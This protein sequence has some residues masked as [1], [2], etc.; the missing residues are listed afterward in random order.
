MRLKLETS[1]AVPLTRQIVEQVRDLCAGGALAPGDRL[2]SIRELAEELSLNPNTIL[3]AYERLTAEGLLERRHG[4]GTYVA[5]N[6]PRGRRRSQE[7]AWET[8]LERLVRRGRLLGLAGK[9]IRARVDRAL[10]HGSDRS[11]M[12]DR[13]RGSAGSA[14]EEDDPAKEGKG[15]RMKR[16]IGTWAAVALLG[17]A[18]AYGQ[19]DAR[20]A[21]ALE[22]MEA[23][24]VPQMLEQAF[25]AVKQTMPA[26]MQAM[27]ESMGQTNATQEASKAMA[28]SMDI[29]AEEFSWAKVKEDFITLYAETLTTE[30]LKDITAFYR[31]P[32]GQALMRK[33]PE[34]MQR[35]MAL[36]QKIVMR[37]MPRIQALMKEHIEGGKAAA[38]QP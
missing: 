31:S 5:E 20:R 33:Q 34:L 2:P 16:S 14:T 7:E 6:L 15:S 12:A 19:D 9:E 25:A 29:M 37:A 32:A 26:Q 36:S 18:A 30:E 24:N 17:A 4:D 11:N 38:G 21:A 13:L 22:M 23:S 3:R 1:S 10:E 28:A 8:E 27:A 35:S